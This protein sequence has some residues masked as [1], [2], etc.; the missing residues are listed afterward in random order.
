MYLIGIIALYCMV[1]FFCIILEKVLLL[2][3][4]SVVFLLT[5]IKKESS[6]RYIVPGTIIL[7][8]IMAAHYFTPQ[9]LDTV[10]VK[11]IYTQSMIVEHQR[12]QYKIEEV[13]SAAQEGDI[14]IGTFEIVKDGNKEQGI[15]S[16]ISSDDMEIRKDLLS[17]FRQVKSHISNQLIN[18][19]GL[20]NGGLMTSLVLGDTKYMNEER[21]TNMKEL[22]I[23]HVLSISG[24]HFSLLESALKR[25]KLRKISPVILVLYAVF[26]NSIP[27]YRT[28]LILLY[29]LSGKVLKKDSN[30]KTGLFS[31][32]LIQMC[33]QPYL[34]FNQGFLLTYFSTLG[35]L[36]FQ[37]KVLRFFIFVPG[38]LKNSLALTLAALS[39]SLPVIL[40]F[41]PEFS[42][43]VFLGNFLLVPL[44][45]VV[46]YLSFF[47]VATAWLPLLQN[48]ISPFVEA[49]FRLSYN[50]GNFM[51]SEVVSINME[52]LTYLYVPVV[53]TMFL[54]IR[55]GKHK[56]AAVLL[57][58]VLSSG[59]PIGSSLQVYNK[60]GT[61]FIRVTHNF[62][63]YD[64]M[65]Y[66]VAESG[67]FA[68]RSAE[69]LAINKH[70]VDIRPHEKAKGIPLIQIN[71]RTLLLPERLDYYKGTRK[72]YHYIFWDERII[73]VH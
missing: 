71:G 37:D 18:R 24:F 6:I 15:V 47:C 1:C 53:V 50:V 67:Y 22:G 28:V 59:L 48:L 45:T 10:R 26:L 17:K 70:L 43:G 34:V 36:L 11:K 52:Y 2:I 42:I 54:F 73:R 60:Y 7:A 55:T 64:M 4:L 3:I 20:H 16:V 69:T 72:V 5:V 23:M 62:N 25:M 51:G 30:A 40:A 56:T 57:M 39:L 31:A 44:Y 33:L 21:T 41:S 27:G 13:D 58:I 68:L 14:L 8:L 63:K 49:F 35:I 65:D 9:S 66:R 46:T 19:Y 38:K 12:R 32:M 61:P 29:R